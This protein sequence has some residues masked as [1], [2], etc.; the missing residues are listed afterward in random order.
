MQINGSKIVRENAEGKKAEGALESESYLETIL[1]SIF[2]GVVVIDG[3]THKIVTANPKALETIGASKEQVIGKV[4]HTFICPAEKGK[5]PITDLGQTVDK[6]ERVLLRADGQRIPILKTVTTIIWGGRKYL[7]ES[8]IDI[9]ELKKTEKT[10]QK[11]EERFRTLMEEAPIGICNTDLRGKITY[12]NKRFEEAIGYS[13]EEIVGK[14]GFEMGIM[15]DETLK[16]LAKRMKGRL[17]GKSSRLLEGRFKR[18]DGEWIWAE[19]EGRLIKKFGVP[20]GFQLTSRNITERKIAEEER[21]H[22]EERLSILHTYSRDLNTAENTKEIYRLTLDAMQTVLGFEYA[23]FFMI[24]KNMLRIVDQRGYPKPFPL[25]LPLDGSK[26]GISIKAV[27]TG[28][29]V[30]VQDV[31]KD[32]DFVEGLPDVLSELAVPI[33]I[34]QKILGVLNV[35]SK[36]LNAFSEKDQE[37]LEILASHAATAISNLEFAKNLEMRVREIR[38][39]KEKFE[40]FFMDNPEAAVYMDSNFHILNINPRFFKLFGYTFDEVR[41]KHINDIVV[42][43][44]KMEEAEKLDKKALKGYVYYDTVRKGKDGSLVPVSVSVAPIT[45]EGKLTGY[46]TVYTDIK[47]RKRYEERL[48]ALNTYGRKLNM[49]ESMEDIYELTLDAAEK[50]LGF[51]LADILIIEGKMLRV[52]AHRGY[53]EKLSLK[54]PLDGD[55][56][57]TVRAARTGKSVL[58]PDVSKEKAYVE[59]GESIRSELVVPIKV[60]RKVL[61]VL[62]VERKE[63]AAFD[64]K[65]E[66]LL[67]ILASH[68]ATAIRNLEYA[69]SQESYARETQ[70]SREKFERLFRD[71]PEAAVYVDQDFHILDANP[72]FS[73]LFGYS[74]DEIRDKHLLDL[75]VPDD[76]KEEGEA[77]D[78]EARKAY[79][80]YDTV[81]KRK[82]GTLV[83]VSISAA[84]IIVGGQPIG[85]V[86]TYKD[87]TETK[88]YEERLSALNIY[89]QKLNMAESM[90]EIYRLTLDAAEKLLG[91]EI[92]FFMVVDKDMLC[93]VDQRGYPDALSIRLPLDGSKG[94]VSVKAATTGKSINVPDAE[95]DP[96]W[97]V[98]WPG[99]R[100]GLDVPVKFGHNVLGVIG[101][102][103]KSLNAFDEKDQ[104]LLEILASHAATAI[105]NLEHAKNL[106]KQAR[107]I[108]ESQEKFERLFMDN[109]EAAVYVDPDFHVL[110]AN[111][112]FSKLFGYSLSEIKGRHIDEVVVP[113]DRIEEGEM[114]NKKALEGYIY[115]DTVR[116]RKDGTLVP[117]SISAAPMIVDGQFVGTVGL[118]RDITERKRYEE[119]LSALNIYSR[120]LNMAENME[121]IY[122]LTLDATG[123]IFGF[124]FADIFT[125]EESMLC[126]QAH[127]GETKI[128]SL[129]LPLDGD[130]G[131]TV[132]AARTGKSVLVPDV[133]K[134]KAYVEG[135]IE[136]RSELAVPIKIGRRV[137]GVLNVESKKLNGFN[138]RDQELLEILASHAATAI[139]NLDRAKN[140]EAYAAEIRE[141]REKFEKLF[142]DNPEAAVYMDSSFHILDINPCFTKLFGYHLGEVKNKNID[143]VIV[144]KDKME[145]A[146]ML[147]EK[148][149]K[150][151]VY[152]DTVRQRK[153]GSPVP[154]SISG[155]PIIVDDRLVG[156]IGLYK[157]ITERRQMEKKLEEYSQHL[158]E[159]VEERTRQLKEAHEQLVKS[160]RLA[161]IGQVAAMVGHDLRNPLTGI[162]GAT[163]YLKKKLG[164][165]MDEKTMEMMKLIEKDIEHSNEIITDLMEYSKEIRLELTETTPKSIVKDALTLVKVPENVQISDLT[166]GKPKIKMDVEKMKRVFDN[167][168]KN[169][170]DAMPICG[171]LTITSRE[172]K[173]NVEIAFADTGIG[174]TKEIMGKI[175]TPF[176]TTKARGMG[177]GLAICKRIIEAHGGSISVE[178]TAGKG[179]TFTIT[180]PI[181]PKI[182]E[183]SKEC[184][185]EKVIEFVE[186]RVKELEE[187]KTISHKKPR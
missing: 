64:E 135:G 161:A 171:E 25:E 172:S 76:K 86:G 37:L 137:L 169:A 96:N 73:E 55:K 183:R 126:L 166:Q 23:D 153:D 117:V 101:V 187:E 84:P 6:S 79:I 90:K 89:S 28:N 13:R 175:W 63:L 103:S 155:A 91:F 32:I 82:D 168:I 159:L 22:F 98:F 24:D 67:E 174:M 110:D 156:T 36:E 185:K 118:Y 60:G 154:V 102:D 43:K 1:N 61:G 97:V 177:L 132:M 179:T 16:L 181:K 85:Y 140:L 14:N 2:S 39:S 146:K 121:E 184:N 3:E 41:G 10:L 163:Y 142:M 81:R 95:K 127:Q 34:R 77:L 51:E 9:T 180:I 93:T 139:S 145:E 136:M 8:I 122:E 15:S 5:C 11:S 57:I 69:R 74:L 70:E 176:F 148:F 72:R 106:E 68:T 83:P 131:I 7:I 42:P 120:K 100:S 160:E 46:I 71:N 151:P 152:Y 38:E 162:K 18:K 125:T 4:C 35:E 80:H 130:K 116:K 186:T 143:D 114:L 56:G 87:I 138:E 17:M 109:P 123:K 47:E 92:A 44:D 52:V 165:K 75:I 29:S 170:V 58:V 49:A 158:E 112:R 128:S 173:G 66:K 26:K 111:P 107:E 119:R 21:K 108:R 12:V 50:T 147:G 178:S 164:P 134:E 78:R 31:R 149:M 33:K 157:D 19:V 167:L 54:L 27:K 94:G 113:K 150:G 20:I 30:L 59:T 144:P 104:E 141:S 62:N 133:S 88:R 124:E 115:Y 65:D 45:V 53:S 182:K 99:I 48:S 129:K 105:S 40:R